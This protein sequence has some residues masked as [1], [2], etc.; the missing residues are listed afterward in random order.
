M[1]KQKGFTIIELI[2]VI[3][4]IAVLAAIVLVN[5]TQYISKGK[6][7][8]IEGNMATLLT[9]SATYLDQNPTSHGLD[10]INANSGCDSDADGNSP[11]KTAI[12][13]AGGTLTCVGDPN[14]QNW[15]GA[16]ATMPTGGTYA[17]YCVDST[18]YKGLLGGSKCT[19]TT[20]TCQ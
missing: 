20:Y 2:V 6:A 17:S 12:T 1:Y 10:F 15:C 14:S 8:A 16:V 9:N 13:N 18:G 4:I 11:I 19:D 7:A 5:V 3:A